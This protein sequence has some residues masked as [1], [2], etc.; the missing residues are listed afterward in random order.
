MRLYPPR[1]FRICCDGHF[2][3]PGLLRLLAPQDRFPFPTP[4]LAASAFKTVWRLVTGLEPEPS[5]AITSD[6]R[7]RCDQV[8]TLVA[9]GRRAPP[10]R[11][12]R[13]EK[14]EEGGRGGP[15]FL[16]FSLSS[17][18]VGTSARVRIT[19]FLHPPGDKTNDKGK[20]ISP[21][22]ASDASTNENVGGPNRSENASF[23]ELPGRRHL[24]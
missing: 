2:G 5:F 18:L 22:R 4:L 7:P 15:L 17:Y 10:Q 20:N 21:Q 13:R 24:W 16:F 11:E 9:R 3:A 12:R 6:L 1:H 23:K 14:E 19:G 8:R